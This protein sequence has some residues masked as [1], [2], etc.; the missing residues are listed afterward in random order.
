MPSNAA[1]LIP[2]QQI[3]AAT[4]TKY[5]SP[6]AGKGTW[7]DKFTVTNTSAGAVT[8][9]V[10]LVPDGETPADTN[11]IIKDKSL[12]A[13]ATDL[14]PEVTGK[15]LAP[16]DFIAWDASAATSLTGGANGREL[17]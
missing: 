3:E 14:A 16:G 13:A 5:T 10:W 2:H 11:L 9:S 1:V 12:A 17:T 8:Y 4:T 7:I 15:F 6:T